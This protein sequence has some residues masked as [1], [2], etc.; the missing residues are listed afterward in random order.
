MISLVVI[1][2]VITLLFWFFQKNAT[3]NETL[4]QEGC[5]EIERFRNTFK[6]E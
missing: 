2:V 4:F 1:V 5:L 3:S 6:T